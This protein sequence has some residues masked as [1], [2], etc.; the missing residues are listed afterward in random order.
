[1]KKKVI[2]CAIIVALLVA[3]FSV[4][5]VFAATEELDLTPATLRTLNDADGKEGVEGASGPTYQ[6][7]GDW[8]WTGG[9]S[10]VGQ[11]D[12]LMPFDEEWTFSQTDAHVLFMNFDNYILI[13]KDIDLSK[14]SKAVIS[15]S[16]D[17]S[18]SADE[19]EI[20]FF[21]KAASFGS[22]E[23]RKTDGLIASGKTTAANGESWNVTRDMEIALD[24]NYKGDLYLAHYMKE[25]NGVCVT[26]IELT[27][28]DGSS[29]GQTTGGTATPTPTT[30]PTGGQTGNTNTGD[31]SYAIIFAAAA[32]VF[33]VVFKKK[34]TV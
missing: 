9:A 21:T 23:D 24:S 1:M 10:G 5:N 20:G 27:L 31:M 19:N 29:S 34:V 32:I 4:L 15:Y 7:V 3:S 17:G 18:F 28:K 6:F 30:K 11:N 2:S 22:K 8:H 13:A 16:T 12:Y 26:G 14:Y 33:T 25:A